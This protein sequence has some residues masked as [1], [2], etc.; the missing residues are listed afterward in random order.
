MLGSFVSDA[1]LL[2]NLHVYKYYGKTIVNE[3]QWLRVF[4]LFEVLLFALYFFMVIKNKW[5][6]FFIVISFAV[7]LIPFFQTLNAP[8]RL[9]PFD[10]EPASTSAII[11]ILFSL[12]YLYHAASHPQ[13]TGKNFFNSQFWFAIGIMIYMAGNLFMFITYNNFKPVDA[14]K[15]GAMIFSLMNIIKNIFFSIGMLQ[16]EE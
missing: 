10:S 8:P 15:L 4:T 5:L 6:R 14:A 7:F 16:K 3:L 13:R 9:A 12:V 11:C 1:T 2:Y